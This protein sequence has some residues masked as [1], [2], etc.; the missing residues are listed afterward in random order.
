MIHDYE[1][2]IPTFHCL[3]L[4]IHELIL[5]AIIRYPVH[6]LGVQSHVQSYSIYRKICRKSSY[7]R[8]PHHLQWQAAE[9]LAYL[10][11]FGPLNPVFSKSSNIRAIIWNW[12]GTKRWRGKHSAQNQ[13]PVDSTKR[14]IFHGTG[15][16]SLGHCEAH[17]GAPE[18]WQ[19]S[20][21]LWQALEVLRETGIH[22]TTQMG[23]GNPKT[24]V[25]EC[26]WRYLAQKNTTPRNNICRVVYRKLWRKKIDSVSYDNDT[27]I[28]YS[29]LK[30]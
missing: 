6:S 29:G 17:I 22:R 26:R 18:L 19:C 23:P 12:Q 9:Q 7:V 30:E 1:P 27:Y 16:E 4:E 14:I 15:S 13:E 20:V 10:N 25:I 8:I 3:P 28:M 11:E 5:D 24:E 21:R 2:K